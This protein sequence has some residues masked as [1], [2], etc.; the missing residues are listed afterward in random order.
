MYSYTF[1]SSQLYKLKDQ[2][3]LIFRPKSSINSFYVVLLQHVKQ[4]LT[5]ISKIGLL[6]LQFSISSLSKFHL[7]C[8]SCSFDLLLSFFF[9][10][11]ISLLRSAEVWNFYSLEV[12][13]VF[14]FCVTMRWFDVSVSR[15]LSVYNRLTFWFVLAPWADKILF[16][17]LMVSVFFLVAY[18]AGSVRSTIRS[19]IVYRANA[20]YKIEEQDKQC[21]WCL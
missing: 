18:V 13:F 19:F 6:L 7:I 4:T 17:W 2:Q 1:C 16:Q 21:S 11:W 9:N 12:V 8:C 3:Y 20:I 14:K 10:L 15:L 5:L